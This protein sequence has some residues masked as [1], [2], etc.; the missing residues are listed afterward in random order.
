MRWLTK[1]MIL[2][3]NIAPNND[4]EAAIS[5]NFTQTDPKQKSGQ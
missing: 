1:S 5:E 4:D 3:P 2:S